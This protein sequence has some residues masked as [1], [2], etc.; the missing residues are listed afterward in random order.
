ME[1][2]TLKTIR[3]SNVEARL[4]EDSAREHNMTVSDVVRDAVVLWREL[5][6]D[7]QQALGEWTSR[8]LAKHGSGAVLRAELTDEFGVN[9][10]VEGVPEDCIREAVFDGVNQVQLWTGDRESDAR[11]YLGRVP[12]VAGAAITVPVRSLPA[13]GASDVHA[14]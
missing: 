5:R 1:R 8:L 2:P 9:V 12:V 10:E 11:V 13:L 7:R 14:V 4:L 3:F 6:G